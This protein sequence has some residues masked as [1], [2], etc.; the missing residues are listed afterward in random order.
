MNGNRNLE[1]LDHQLFAS[2][3]SLRSL[4][5]RNS[6]IS[7]LDP[8]LA[9]LFKK[10]NWIAVTSRKFSCNCSVQWLSLL[11]NRLRNDQQA[12]AIGNSNGNSTAAPEENRPADRGT[13][14]ATIEPDRIRLEAAE[15]SIVLCSLPESVAGANLLDLTTEQLGCYEV[16]SL[17]PI[18]IGIVIGLFIFIAVI[19]LCVINC[20]SGTA[21]CLKRNKHDSDDLSNISKFATGDHLASLQSF[22]NGPSVMNNTNNY[23]FKLGLYDHRT[24]T[25]K[26]R[27]QNKVFSMSDKPLIGDLPRFDTMYKPPLIGSNNFSNILMPNSKSTM[28]STSKLIKQSSADDCSQPMINRLTNPYQV[29]P[30]NQLL[31]P[32]YEQDYFGGQQLLFQQQRPTNTLHPGQLLNQFGQSANTFHT[33]RLGQRPLNYNPPHQTPDDDLNEG[34][35]SDHTY[36]T[37]LNGNEI[38]AQEP[39]PIHHTI[40]PS[41]LHRRLANSDCSSCSS[42]EPLS[43]LSNYP[44]NHDRPITEL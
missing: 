33:Q 16:K 27:S 42:A 12:K 26:L 2:L 11:L 14:A 35:F 21:S 9:N 38:Y 28:I 36:A 31:P 5:L 19:V 32:G 18:V 41:H 40:N 37:V 7:T 43:R 17:L 44:S 22:A 1:A 20:R 34:D 10:L 3:V 15:E 24:A 29:V 6:S 8:R 25:G 4:S 30:V 13:A 39:G 23:A